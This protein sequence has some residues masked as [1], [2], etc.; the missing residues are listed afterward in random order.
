MSTMAPPDQ[1][2][3][4]NRQGKQVLY[5]TNASNVRRT[6]MAELLQTVGVQCA[7]VSTLAIR[8]KSH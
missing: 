4:N 5:V 8:Q 7:A 1:R 2:P 3:A 6:V